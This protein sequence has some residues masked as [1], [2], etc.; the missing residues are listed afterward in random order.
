[1][2]L[3]ALQNLHLE[4]TID[5]DITP[6]PIYRIGLYSG[7]AGP[8]N[9]G[10]FPT[11]GQQVQGADSDVVATVIDSG[12]THIDVINLVGGTLT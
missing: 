1:M 11:L 4:L 7:Q 8:P 12:T 2:Y 6:T 5:L 9:F 10:I 3:L